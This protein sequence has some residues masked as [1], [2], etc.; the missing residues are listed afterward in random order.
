MIRK[1]VFG[2][3]GLLAAT[4]WLPERAQAIPIFAQRYHLKCTMCHS[5]MPELNAFGNAFRDNGYRLPSS[6]SRHGT[7]G[8]ALRYQLEYE[9][10][11]DGGRRFTPGGVLLSNFD[12]GEISAFLHYNLG[13][14]GGP[15]GTYLAFLSLFNEHTNSL[16]RA[17]EFELPLPHS[18]GQRLDD[19]QA[20][21]YETTHVGLNDLTLAS[22]RIGVQGQ[23]DIGTA[24]IAITASLG[25]FKG[26]PYGGAP[27]PTGE[28]TRASQPEI[29]LFL[30]Q[31]V[32]SAFSV[33]AEELNGD[34]AI[35]QTGKLF[36]FS[37]RYRRSGLW[38]SFEGEHVDVLAQQWWGSDLN[39]DG[40][41]DRLGSTGGFVRLRYWPFT[42]HHAFIAARYDAAANPSPLRDW[43]FYGGFEVTTHARIVVQRVQQL[44]G[45]PGHFGAALTIG[46]PW[47][48]GY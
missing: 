32:L 48:L 17:G 1:L 6:F 22:P 10:D 28:T 47:P 44:D 38:A 4:L 24:R 23:R 2:A 20:Y 7:T 37:D 40:F 3:L 36:E 35:N 19:L 12:A 42:W 9:K 16:F 25:E 33:G 29:G 34:R 13:A 21:G 11:P 43:V 30:T 45:G 14:G 39:A 18:P 26:A 31:R 46:F 8:V 27:I 15:S 5:V 41:R